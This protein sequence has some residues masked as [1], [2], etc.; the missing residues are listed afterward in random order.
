M[1]RGVWRECRVKINPFLLL[2]ML[3]GIQPA[4]ADHGLWRSAE[5]RRH[6]AIG[7]HQGGIGQ[8]TV[9]HERVVLSE[10]LIIHLLGVWEHGALPGVAH[11]GRLTSVSQ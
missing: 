9:E 3:A 11:Y 7:K 1:A 8:K 6:W 5:E 2:V 4:L 10:S